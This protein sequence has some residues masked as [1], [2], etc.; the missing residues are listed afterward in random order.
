MRLPRANERAVLCGQPGFTLLEMIVAMVV[1]VSLMLV[2]VQAMARVQDTWT[3]TNAKVREAVDAR[4]G[5]ETLS[6]TVSRATLNL[7][8]APDSE[9]DPKLMQ[10]D[11]DLHF[12]CGPADDLVP[13]VSGATGHAIF[14]QAPNGHAGP[15]DRS[16]TGT[17]GKAEYDSLPNVLNAWGYFVQFDEDPARLPTFL[18]SARAALGSVPKRYRFRL[19][20]FRQPAHELKLFEMTGGDTSVA[21]LATIGA[22]A[23][24]YSW[25]TAPLAE[26]R[27]SERRR[28]AVIAENILAMIVL[29]LQQGDSAGV[30]STGQT[31]TDLTPAYLYDTREHQWNGT[32]ANGANSRHRLP[33]AVQ[34]SLVV[35]DDRDWSKLPD[36]QAVTAGYALRGQVNG[37]FSR[38]GSFSADMGSLTGELNRRRMRHRVI[39]TTL[40]IP[41]GGRSADTNVE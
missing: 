27:Q 40:Q 14:F 35:L 16:S 41:A 33:S 24:L 9:D 8:W 7:R 22:Q 13:T 23:D 31:M 38:P 10:R 26:P 39:T 34:I 11:S 2:V 28:C 29:P 19:M 36:D 12:V 4:T 21:R 32:R 30:A 17:A 3:S 18:S 6:R 25:F 20:E 1:V 15:D 37:K 5:M